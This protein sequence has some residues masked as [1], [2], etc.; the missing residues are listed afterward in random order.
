[1][2]IEIV[3]LVTKVP[4]DTISKSQD[5]YLNVRVNYTYQGPARRGRLGAVVTQET[6]YTEF[7]EIGST[8]KEVYVDLPAADTPRALYSNI[9]G[10]PLAGCAPKPGYGIK[11]YAL[12]LDGKPEWGCKNVI[13]V[14][15]AHAPPPPPPA[16]PKV[17]ALDA[18]EIGH[19]SATLKGRLIDTGYWSN[20]DCYFEWGK[21]TSY[22]KVTPKVRMYEGEEGLTF[23]SELLHLLEP[24][25]TYHF[26][27]FVVPLGER[28][29]GVVGYGS[30]RSFT[31]KAEVVAGF[32]M[33]VKNPPA[34]AVLWRAGCVMG[35]TLPYMKMP[36]PLNYQWRWAGAVPDTTENFFVYA[37]GT[38]PADIR[39]SDQFPFRL[40]A[41]KNYVFDFAAH[42][43]RDDGVVFKH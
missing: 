13:E 4:C 39:Q 29:E 37:R 8:R 1:M 6:F 7:D 34:G 5:E 33:R 28:S 12:D 20:V 11:V 24:D 42:E 2:A 10:M 32:T 19:D 27:A 41:G 31:T 38:D 26:R 3:A 25:T 15:E 9:T 36:Q 22:G 40:R 18:T 21:T 23:F 43:M 35:G 16:A 14:R 17:D 30:D